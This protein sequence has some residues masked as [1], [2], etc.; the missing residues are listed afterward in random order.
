MGTFSY[1]RK[2]GNVVITFKSNASAQIGVRKQSDNDATYYPQSGAAGAS[3]PESSLN[4][5]DTYVIGAYPDTAQGPVDTD[6]YVCSPGS[7]VMLTGKAAGWRNLPQFKALSQADQNLFTS[8]AGN[9]GSSVPQA[10]RESICG[11][12]VNGATFKDS[13]LLPALLDSLRLAPEQCFGPMSN[14][15][16]G[17]SAY[18]SP[19]LSRMSDKDPKNAQKRL[20]RII[21]AIAQTLAS[22]ATS[23]AKTILSN[24]LDAY[25]LGNPVKLILV[26]SSDPQV[27]QLPNVGDL[28]YGN[29]SIGLNT[30]GFG[31]AP[32]KIDKPS[33]MAATA[34]HGYG[35]ARRESWHKANPTPNGSYEH[36]VDE[37]FAY[38]TEFAVTW[39]RQGR[40]SGQDME[41]A[42]DA[43]NKGPYI[44]SQATGDVATNIKNA[45][46]FIT[47]SGKG[48][49]PMQQA[50]DPKPLAPD[51]SSWSY[52]ND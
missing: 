36:Y 1:A 32:D 48:K 30:V 40:P 29:G 11:G 42:T 34:A 8:F 24:T 45:T 47:L 6:F 4:T 35:H 27:A 9:A 28:F 21:G 46:A 13:T 2:G 37:V 39:N 33:L 15:L 20:M 51:G 43:L 26:D 5:G 49:D 17:N 7:K 14:L 50:P 10:T 31:I 18:S 3:I 23:E 41:K 19:D 16:S 44:Y 12:I 38:Y 22:A 52:L 25:A